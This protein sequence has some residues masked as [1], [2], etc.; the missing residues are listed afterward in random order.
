MVI[1]IGEH[2]SFILVQF[3]NPGIARKSKNN[4]EKETEIEE[5]MDFEIILCK[6][7]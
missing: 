6:K 1:L 5:N 4:K 7:C 2:L 3:L